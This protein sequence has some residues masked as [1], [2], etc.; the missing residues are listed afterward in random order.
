MLR[1]A[2][3]AAFIAGSPP[4]RMTLAPDATSSIASAGKRSSRALKPRGSTVRCCPSMIP[5]C[6]SSS[7]KGYKVRLL[8]PAPGQ[9]AKPK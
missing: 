5:N 2:A 7:K 8:P 4:A 3:C 9:N 1:V 6:R